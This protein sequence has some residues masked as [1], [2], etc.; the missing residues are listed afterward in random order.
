[1]FSHNDRHKFIFLSDREGIKWQADALWYIWASDQLVSNSSF[2]VRNYIKQ[3]H[4][5][6]VQGLPL[7]LCN[8]FCFSLLLILGL[9]VTFQSMLPSLQT[10]RDFSGN[11]LFSFTADFL[12]AEDFPAFEGCNHVASWFLFLSLNNYS[13]FNRPLKFTFPWCWIMLS[14]LHQTFSNHC[15][16]FC[17]PGLKTVFRPSAEFPVCLLVC[18]VAK[19]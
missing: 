19:I 12:F 8:V 1:M 3:S 15:T 6:T 2:P 7:Y 16:Y 18:S 4:Y 10:R 11:L 13:Q 14:A 9:P 5:T 17:I